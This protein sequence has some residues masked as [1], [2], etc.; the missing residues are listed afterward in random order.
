MPAVFSKLSWNF[1]FLSGCSDLAGNRQ[2]RFLDILSIYDL[3]WWL[4]SEKMA[5]W[6]Q[7]SG[8]K[9]RSFIWTKRSTARR[10]VMVHSAHHIALLLASLMSRYLMN[11]RNRAEST[12]WSRFSPPRVEFCS[13]G[14][15]RA[16]RVFEWAI[17]QPIV[18]DDPW[19][20][21]DYLCIRA[22]TSARAFAATCC[23]RLRARAA[24]GPSTF[25]QCASQWVSLRA[26]DC[27]Y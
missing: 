25:W 22:L 21:I 26:A 20:H 15:P 11:A 13:V 2:H 9:Y 10:A 27:T 17:T 19:H 7:G 5:F 14:F 18:R 6:L 12:Q 23:A 16:S 3:F 1:H 24:A 8:T 4:V